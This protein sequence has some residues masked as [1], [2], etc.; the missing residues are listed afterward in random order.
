MEWTKGGELGERRYRVAITDSEYGSHEP[1]WAVLS[2][3]DVELVKFQCRTEDDVIKNCR[4]ADALL[5]QYAPITRKVIDHLERAKVIARYGIGVDNID[6]KAATEKGIFVANVVY[7]IYDVADH[8]VGLILSLV[9][10]IPW[11]SQSTRLGEWDWKKFQPVMRLRGKTVGIVGFGRVGREVAERICGF[12]VEVIAYDP[13]LP[14]KVF[15]E[16][17]VEK[18][19]METLLKRSDIIT[20]HVALTEKTRHM[21]GRDELR[22]MKKTAILVNASRGA[23]IDEAALYTALRE[24]WVA[25]A[26]LD[27][28]EREPLTRDNPLLGL[29]NVVITPHMAWYS[30]DSLTEIQRRAAEEVARVLRGQPPKSLVNREVLKTKQT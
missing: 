12:G 24:K 26:G 4:D 6:L 30:I 8:T 27:V 15:Q 19:D 16:R 28:L 9:R 3:L 13:Y 11:A 25:S 20:V 14:L 2:K 23:V 22:K 1:E 5:N 17:H 29:D 21:I 18:V 10:K 7:E